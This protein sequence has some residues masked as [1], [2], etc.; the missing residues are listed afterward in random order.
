MKLRSYHDDSGDKRRVRLLTPPKDNFLKPDGH[1]LL[2][3]LAPI[4][5]SMQ[6][7]RMLPA[8]LPYR[9]APCMRLSVTGRPSCRVPSWSVPYGVVAGAAN[10]WPTWDRFAVALCFP[11][12]KGCFLS[13]TTPVECFSLKELQELS[14]LLERQHCQL[15]WARGRDVRQD[16]SSM[17]R[18]Q[19]YTSEKP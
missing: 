6:D 12:L 8:S 18:S 10:L 5:A 17:V 11:C 9:S 19:W 16:V 15:E 2:A 1:Y 14:P 7:C 4:L 3:G 13:G